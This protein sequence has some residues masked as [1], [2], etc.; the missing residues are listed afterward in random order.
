MHQINNLSIAYAFAY[1]ARW[2]LQNLILLS[3]YRYLQNTFST[4]IAF[5]II[6]TVNESTQLHKWPSE[7]VGSIK[8]IISWLWISTTNLFCMWCSYVSTFF[9]NNRAIHYFRFFQIK[10]SS[11]SRIMFDEEWDWFKSHFPLTR[12]TWYDV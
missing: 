1:C 11:S 10:P 9:I 7:S 3:L 4:I 12:F 8:D 6:C 2:L 5:Y